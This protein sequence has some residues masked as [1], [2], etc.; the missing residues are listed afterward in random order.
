MTDLDSFFL[1]LSWAY[2]DQQEELEK[3]E[4][5]EDKPYYWYEPWQEPQN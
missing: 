5:L 4:E 3:Q 1:R 2:E